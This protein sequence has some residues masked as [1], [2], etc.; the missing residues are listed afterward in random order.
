MKHILTTILLITIVGCT[1]GPKPFEFTLSGKVIGQDSG[2]ICYFLSNRKGDH[3]IIPFSNGEFHYTGVAPEV[4]AANL[5]FYDDV[6][7]KNFR[8]YPLLLEPGETIVELHRDSIYEKSKTLKGDL[9]LDLQMLKNITD[10]YWEDLFSSEYSRGQIDSLL[11]GAYSDSIYNLIAE[12]SDNFL[13]IYQLTKALNWNMFER[14]RLEEALNIVKDENL[15]ASKYYKTIYSKFLAEENNVNSIGGFAL[16]FKLQN[17]MGKNIAFSDINNDR[18]V[19]VQYLGTWCN[20]QA[21][22]KNELTPIYQ[23]FHDKGF[24]IIDVTFESNYDR[25]KEYIDAED[26]P[27][28][29]LIELEFENPS[30]TYYSKQLFRNGNYLV[31]REGIVIA[32]NLTSEVLYEK[33]IEILSPGKLEEFHLKKWNLPDSITILD[34]EE[35]IQSLSEL[36]EI[37]EGKAVFIDRWAT[38]CS[39]CLKEFTYSA[40]LYK[41]LKAQDIELVYLNSD[42][43]VSVLKWLEFIRSYNLKGSHLRL[44]DEL[45]ADMIQKDGFIPSIPQYLI[46]NEKG[47]VV[48]KNAFR[49]SDKEILFAQ[50]INKLMID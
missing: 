22:L 42:E 12:N 21:S 28:I 36:S 29:S 14:D 34:Q 8:Y 25:W 16:D 35:P 38:W 4:I 24:E 9:N 43:K 41:F 46:L 6:K 17:S 45:K 33:L 40:D 15:R 50:V 30:P 1:R 39:P 19:Y 26:F 27:W 44:T 49:P 47:E 5:A 18:M 7:T 11:N 48:E 31:D 23:E 37:V 2:E 3:E 20:S 13:S 10:R 32:N